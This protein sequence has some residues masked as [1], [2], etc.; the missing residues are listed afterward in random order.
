M[1]LVQWNALSSS[2]FDDREPVIGS[3]PLLADAEMPWFGN[4][5]EWNLNGV[6]RRPAP[7]N[8]E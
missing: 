4:A 5:V 6:I 1:S 7:C 2:V 8:L 3:H